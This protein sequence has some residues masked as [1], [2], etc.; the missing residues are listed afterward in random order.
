MKILALHQYTQLLLCS[1]CC[2]V[3]HNNLLPL[4]M[5]AY[6]MYIGPTT[7]NHSICSM[8]RHT[9]SIQFQC[10]MTPLCHP[11]K[12]APIH[13]KRMEQCDKSSHWGRNL[14][15]L[16]VAPWVIIVWQD[17]YTLGTTQCHLCTRYHNHMILLHKQKVPCVYEIFS[18]PF[19]L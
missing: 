5:S 13:V 3:V 18:L 8:E 10:H 19:H 11:W 14:C 1:D 4:R 9:P 6:F 7:T 16:G 17:V 15:P 2:P 12:I